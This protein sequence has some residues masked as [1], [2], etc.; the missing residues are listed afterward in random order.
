[1]S[2]Y[3]RGRS[4]AEIALAPA[5]SSRSHPG[6]RLGRRALLPVLGMTFAGGMLLGLLVVIN[7]YVPA[8]L[9]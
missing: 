8:S 1:M 5:R 4:A 3:L 9:S 7:H 2:S 6:P